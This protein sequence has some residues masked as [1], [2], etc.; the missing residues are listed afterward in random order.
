MEILRYKSV[1]KIIMLDHDKEVIDLISRH[2]GHAKVAIADPRLEIRYTDACDGLNDLDFSF[3][4]VVN[5][6]FDLLSKRCIGLFQRLTAKLAPGGVCADLIYRHVFERDTLRGTLMKLQREFRTAVAL[7][8][9]PE[10]PGVLHLLTIWSVSKEV[11]QDIRASKNDEHLVW[12]RDSLVNPCQYFDPR[13]VP[14]YFYLPPYLKKLIA[15][16]LS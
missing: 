1:E 9:V 16:D 7:V 10:Y 6:A 14:Y 4:L 11:R 5:D 12:Q 3:D 13:F 15:L 8:V 2:Y